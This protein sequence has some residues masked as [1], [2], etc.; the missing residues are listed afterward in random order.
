MRPCHSRNRN[1]RHAAPGVRALA[2]M[3][4]AALLSGVV[5]LGSVEPVRAQEAPRT[6]FDFLFRPF[7]KTKRAEKGPRKQA[8]VVKPK[9][10]RRKS[11]AAA[12]TVSLSTGN[13]GSAV[14]EPLVAE[15]AVDA[16]VVLVVGDFVAGGMADG[17]VEAFAAS[18]KIRVVDRASGSSGFVRDDFYD[19]PGKIGEIIA[20][21]KPAIVVV[22]LGANDRQQMKIGTVREQPLTDAWK[23]EYARRV[24]AFVQGVRQ[25]G[26]PLVWVGQPSFKP[27]S[28]ATGMIALNDLVRNEVEKAGSTYIDIWDGFVDENGAF[29]TTGPDVNGQPVRLRANDGINLTKAGRRKLAFYAEKPIAKLLGPG[30]APAAAVPA[31]PS[32]GSPAS[33]APA[34]DRT[35]PIGL[36]DPALDGGDELLGAIPNPIGRTS[37]AASVVQGGRADDFRAPAI[38]SRTTLPPPPGS[39]VGE[40]AAR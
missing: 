25:A 35:A 10:T 24:G 15:K 36:D 40:T 29:V 27:T 21:E 1:D 17:L 26:L 5:A 18:A 30:V 23:T 22:M 39:P 13:D 8:P 37:S 34:I 33:P 31:V 9:T 3:L 32:P 19:W 28:M 7:N 20:E 6:I 38:L 14:N 4:L 16:R 11:S 12:S 2:M